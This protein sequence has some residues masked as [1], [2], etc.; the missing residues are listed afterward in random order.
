MQI[1]FGGGN[2]LP[3]VAGYRYGAILIN[4]ASRMRFSMIMKS[5]HVICDKSKILFR[6]IETFTGTKMQYFWSDN[7]GV[8]QLL[9]LYFE[10]K[11]I[12]WEKSALY[13]QDQNGVA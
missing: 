9:V 3:G 7:A 5:K 4:K 12:I 8:Y 2:T 13:A 11:D 6:K 1:L 10:E